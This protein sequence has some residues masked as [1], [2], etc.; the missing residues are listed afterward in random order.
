MNQ[1][2][3]SLINTDEDTEISDVL[4][5]TFDDC[6]DRELLANHFP[7][8]RLNLLETEGD[9]AI[10]NIQSQDNSLNLVTYRKNL[11][12]MLDT[13]GPAH[14]RDVDQAFNAIFQLNECAVVRE[15]DYF[16]LNLT[17]NRVNAFN[18][19]PWI[20][21]DLLQAERNTLTF[22]VV[23]KNLDF[24]LLT[25][26]EDIRRVVNAPPGHIRDV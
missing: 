1:T 25:N 26:R 21:S 4:D 11:V 24:D 5:L 18:F 9:T 15:A 19:Q 12:W 13:L 16:A 10:R 23:F 2:V 17:T 22:T 20:R 6:T 14:F 7:W 3:D 8:I